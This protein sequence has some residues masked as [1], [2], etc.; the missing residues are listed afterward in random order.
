MQCNLRWTVNTLYWRLARWMIG[1]SKLKFE[2][3]SCCARL[4]VI[5][6]KMV[7][8]YMVWSVSPPYHRHNCLLMGTDESFY[9]VSEFGLDSFNMFARQAVII[10]LS[11]QNKLRWCRHSQDTSLLPSSGNIMEGWIPQGSHNIWWRNSTST[12]A[13]EHMD[14]PER[15]GKADIFFFSCLALSLKI[16]YYY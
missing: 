13:R 2:E 15:A 11:W 9:I 16:L 8:S 10:S 4:L 6:K 1:M 12:L 7:V 5:I 14:E 3:F